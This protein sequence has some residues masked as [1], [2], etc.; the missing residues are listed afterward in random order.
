[1]SN[2]EDLSAFTPSGWHTITPRITVKDALGL[3]KFI[4]YVFGTDAHYRDDVPT[5]VTIGDSKLMV[6]EA[7]SRAEATAFLYVYVRNVDETYKR[8][9]D[10][11]AESIED[12]GDLPYG[13]RRAMVKDS[14]GNTW[15]IATYVVR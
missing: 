9:L 7:V 10:R 5:I 12:P 8:A 14:W 6:S 15:Q 11:G 13:D 4:N 3:V 2:F 1:M